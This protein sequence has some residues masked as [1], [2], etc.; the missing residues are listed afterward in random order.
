MCLGGEFVLLGVHWT[1]SVLDSYFL[2]N[3][4]NFQ[5]LFLQIFFLTLPV[6]SPFDTPTLH[7]LVSLMA[8]VHFSFST[9]VFILSLRLD[10]FIYAVFKFTDSSVCSNNAVELLWWIFCF[11]YFTFQLR[12]FYFLLFIFLYWWSLFSETSFLFFIC[13]WFPLAL[14]VYLGQLI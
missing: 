3:L 9:T 8:P 2:S 5:P 10:N 14:Q 6:S 11:S 7:M 12:N 1:S 13:P 4:G